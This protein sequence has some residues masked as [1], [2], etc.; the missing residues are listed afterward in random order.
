MALFRKGNR[1]KITVKNSELAQSAVGPGASVTFSDNVQAKVSEN[2]L[3]EIRALFHDLQG[4]VIRARLGANEPEAMRRVDELKGAIAADPPD[5]RKLGEVLDWFAASAPTVAG[6]VVGLV[7][8]PPVGAVVAA[9]GT[10][11]V[12][13]YKKVLERHKRP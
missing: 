11:A 8:S 5:T 10:A 4:D 9:G 6:A 12:N 7:A 13:V 1:S 3:S 2:D